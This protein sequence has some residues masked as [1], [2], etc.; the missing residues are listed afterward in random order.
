MI[1]LKDSPKT[2]TF[3]YVNVS[4]I[5]IN[6]IVF[7]RQL[8]MTN[9]ELQSF[10][11]TYG[12]IPQAV[13]E[14]LTQGHF[15]AIITPLLTYQ[16]MHGGWLHIGS[17]MLYLWVFGDNIE[18]RVGHSKYLLFYLLVGSLAGFAQIAI[19]TGST[20]PIIGASGAVAGVLG[21][22]LVSCPRARVLALI[23]VFIIFTLAEVPAVIFLGF[24]FILQ[25]F[26]GIAS[27][28]AAG[29]SI[30]FWAHIGGFVAGLVLV[31]LFGKKIKCE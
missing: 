26:S 31:G 30:A 24:W 7:I 6:I 15:S 3:P 21:A 8:A 20:V 1:P 17:N 4:I 14:A 22:Y 27:I 10:V 25:I 23:P 29:V 11:F 12:L 9:P 13:T 18:D 16:F 28:G 2:R 19:D 5:I